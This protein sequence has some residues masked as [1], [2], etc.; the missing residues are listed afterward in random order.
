M[1]YIVNIN[2]SVRLS[3][4]LAPQ[5]R[6]MAGV[7]T[8]EAYFGR[9]TSLHDPLLFNFHQLLGWTYQLIVHLHCKC[10]ALSF[11]SLKLHTLVR[12]EIIDQSNLNQRWPCSLGAKSVKRANLWP[13]NN[14]KIIIIPAVLCQSVTSGGAHLRDAWAT[15]LRRNIT[16]VASNW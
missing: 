5:Y 3:N 11:A 1:Q 16:P 8:H 12:F 10:P 6:F 4:D 9:L 2:S 15:Q 13:I 7:I 14:K